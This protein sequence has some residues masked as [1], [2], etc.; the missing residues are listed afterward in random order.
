MFRQRWQSRVY[1]SIEFGALRPLKWW[2]SGIRLR[3]EMVLYWSFIDDIAKLKAIW[4]SI[5]KLPKRRHSRNNT[6]TILVIKP[7]HRKH[8]ISVVNGG[9]GQMWDQFSRDES[10]HWE[11]ARI[12]IAR[13]AGHLS[14]TLKWKFQ[15]SEN[16]SSGRAFLFM[17]IPAS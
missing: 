17:E 3:R 8:R 10:V 14:W 4:L 11:A 7:I 9:C 13:I 12:L 6:K 16:I 2:G 1:K 15:A 5:N